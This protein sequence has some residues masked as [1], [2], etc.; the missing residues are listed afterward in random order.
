[1]QRGEKKV[2]RGT[3]AQDWVEQIGK[4]AT[5]SGGLEFDQ[6]SAPAQLDLSATVSRLSPPVIQNADRPFHDMT[7]TRPAS[8]LE[9]K[10][11]PHSLR[12][13]L[14]W[15]RPPAEIGRRL[16]GEDAHD[17]YKCRCFLAV[18]AKVQGAGRARRHANTTRTVYLG[19]PPRAG[20]TPELRAS[21]PPELLPSVDCKVMCDRMIAKFFGRLVQRALHDARTCRPRIS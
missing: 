18:R 11:D 15:A 7:A 5:A 19:P 8:T 10:L 2:E 13:V 20:A 17:L 16:L 12:N 6:R 9:K 21:A 14:D 4:S 3:G 1:M